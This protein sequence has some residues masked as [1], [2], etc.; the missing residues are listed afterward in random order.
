MQY[1][2]KENSKYFSSLF[3]PIPFLPKV[4]DIKKYQ[5]K[6]LLT[7]T[8]LTINKN[9]E[10]FLLAKMAFNL[11]VNLPQRQEEKNMFSFKG[12]R[13]PRH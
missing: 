2:K 6:A 3:C 12:L 1:K 11:S 7:R 4:L 13:F 10:L 9:Q 5:L 8:F